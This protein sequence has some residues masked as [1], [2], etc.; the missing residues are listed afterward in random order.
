MKTRKPPILNI[1]DDTLIH[2][3]VKKTLESFYDVHSVLNTDEAWSY[4]SKIDVAAILLDLAL[5]TQ[6]EGLRFLEKLETDQSPRPPV[7][8]LSG[9]TDF[10]TVR[11]AIRLGAFDYIAKDFDPDDLLLTVRRAAQYSTLLK[12]NDQQDF[13]RTGAHEKH[14]IVGKSPQ[15]VALRKMIEKMRGSTG[16]VIILGETGTGKEAVARQLQGRLNDGTLAPFIA[17]DSSTIQ[18]TMAE[19]LL[20]GHEKGAFTSADRARKG[21]FEEAD[22]GIVYF[23]E[24]G[25]MPIEIQTK[26]LRVIE[27]KEVMRLGSTKVISTEF[28][29]VCATNVDLENMVHAG[30]FKADLYQRLAVLPIEIPPLR[31]RKEDIPLLLSHLIS[32]ERPDLQLNFTESCLE[33]LMAY[34]WPGN[35]RELANVILYVIAMAQGAEIDLSDLP[36]R[37]RD[38]FVA[39]SQMGRDKTFYER[40]EEFEKTVL[41]E[42]LKS[43]SG[44]ISDLALKL[45]MDRS[46]LYSK[47]KHYEIQPAKGRTERE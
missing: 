21:V 1:D 41:L 18:G 16:N 2:M 28:R 26:L 25:N 38:R 40:V 42:S 45:G 8:I 7:I 47:L 20:F 5:R 17:I 39:K 32:R 12:R 14:P 46:H 6:D 9:S 24:I 30:T 36:P 43:H 35:I 22:G 29:V 37:I 33:A 34:P 27:E 4:L 11:Q 23:D 19:A 15:M 44:T 10:G 13:E 31:D 3:T